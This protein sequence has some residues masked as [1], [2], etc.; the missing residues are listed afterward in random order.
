MLGRHERNE[1]WAT[2]WVGLRVELGC[3][4]SWLERLEVRAES[5]VDRMDSIRH[6]SNPNRLTW[7]PFS[8]VMPITISAFHCKDFLER[9][10]LWVTAQEEMWKVC[11]AIVT[12][13]YISRVELIKLKK[14]ESR[15]KPLAELLVKSLVV[16]LLELLCASLLESQAG[17]ASH[18]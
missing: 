1:S 3:E 12:F 9:L 5:R 6:D 17:K 2:S 14:S 16:S 7:I 4:W 11:K 18:G 13:F 8:R 10:I 15:G